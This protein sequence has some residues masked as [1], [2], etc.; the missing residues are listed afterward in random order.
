MAKPIAHVLPITVLEDAP[1]SH[2]QNITLLK[3]QEKTADCLI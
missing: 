2:I 1:S 3:F